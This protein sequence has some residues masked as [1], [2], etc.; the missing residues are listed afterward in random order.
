MSR[1]RTDHDDHANARKFSG[2]VT[3]TAGGRMQT[4]R[5]A[6]DDRNEMATL[7]VPGASQ[8]DRVDSRSRIP[9]S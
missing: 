7:T 5:V 1:S 4:A 2:A 9:A 3:M 8:R 6:L